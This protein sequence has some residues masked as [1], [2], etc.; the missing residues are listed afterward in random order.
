MQ[1]FHVDR[2][3]EIGSLLNLHVVLLLSVPIAPSIRTHILDYLLIAKH[4]GPYQEKVG[5]VLTVSL[6]YP[7]KHELAP[8]RIIISPT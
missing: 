6:H 1:R 2:Y 5:I 3:K 7:L 4:L 8:Q